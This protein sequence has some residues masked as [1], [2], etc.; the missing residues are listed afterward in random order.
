MRKVLTLVSAALLLA[1]CSTPKYTYHFD[2][3]DYNSGK[4]K[5]TPLKPT[6]D[7]GDPSSKETL[8]V[9]EKTL[10]ASADEKTV[11]VTEEKKTNVVSKKEVA[12]KIKAMSKEERK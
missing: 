1:A 5:A 9:D 2:H 7:L 3:Y 12:D 6:T 4:K 11:Y 8:E 10:V